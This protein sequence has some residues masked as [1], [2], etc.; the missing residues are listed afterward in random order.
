MSHFLSLQ[1]LPLIYTI[2]GWTGTI[3]YLAAYLLLSLNKLSSD[4]FLYHLLNIAGAVGLIV[5]ALNL[6]DYPNLAVNICWG[7]I[8]II[9]IVHIRNKR[10]RN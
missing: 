2:I 8:A 6:N 3:A 5:H 1:A 9:A 7:I 10:V 4:Q